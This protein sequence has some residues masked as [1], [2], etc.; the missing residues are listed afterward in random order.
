MP[1]GTAMCIFH[2]TV[3]SMRRWASWRP[4]RVK[5]WELHASSHM[6][7][8]RLKSPSHMSPGVGVLECLCS[9]LDVSR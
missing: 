4:G 5:N 3:R 9:I 7:E 8:W 2:V 1:G 6:G